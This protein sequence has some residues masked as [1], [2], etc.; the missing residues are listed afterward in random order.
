MAGVFEERVPVEILDLV[1]DQLDGLSEVSVVDIG[2]VVEA[3][4][5]AAVL[6]QRVRDRL[7][8]VNCTEIAEER[9]LK[10]ASRTTRLLGSDSNVGALGTAVERGFGKRVF[11]VDEHTDLGFLGVGGDGGALDLAYCGNITALGGFLESLTSTCH[12][13]VN[14]M[15]ESDERVYCGREVFGVLRTELF[16]SH[17]EFDNL[18]V[19]FPWVKELECDYMA[20]DAFIYKVVNSREPQRLFDRFLNHFTLSFPVLTSIKF[21]RPT[22]P[23]DETCNFIDL[24]SLVLSKFQA[25]KMGLMNLFRV[26]SL[27]NWR[28]PRIAEF[29]GH[30][31]KFD[32]TAMTG[33]PERRCSS[34]KENLQYL[35]ELAVNE[36]SDATPYYRTSLIPN[37][38]KQTRLLNW[39]P[40]QSTPI[41]ILKSSSLERLS[42]K[43]L[44][45]DQSATT[46]VHGLFFPNLESLNLEQ[47]DEQHLSPSCFIDRRGSIILTSTPNES[48]DSYSSTMNPITFSSWN[49]LTKLQLIQISANCDHYVF[50]IENLKRSL[51]SIDLKK[52]F[53]TFF[54]EQQRFVVV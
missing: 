54:D 14:L 46:A 21:V 5:G 52:S 39:I 47:R 9:E 25:H 45:L 3:L 38:V 28:L 20:L 37:G 19:S 11:V 18:N 4:E 31:F 29:S 10:Q 7:Q 12:R 49:Q 43:L 30:R 44:K 22:F 32:E 35:R 42:M 50:D 36:T 41:L 2:Y 6:Q 51:P 48:A 53:H 40:I 15:V 13:N 1:L 33:S 27:K 34:L 16:A 8:L 17:W 23:R 26:H 24:S